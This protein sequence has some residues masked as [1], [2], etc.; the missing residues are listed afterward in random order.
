M[1]ARGVCRMWRL[2]A[3]VCLAAVFGLMLTGPALGAELRE[4]ETYVLHADEV[5][6]DDLYVAAGQVTIEGTV[7]SDVF[8]AGQ[9][10]VIEGNVH[11]DV[12]ALAQT[13]I[14]NGEVGD[15]V[16]AAGQAVQVGPDA[17]IHGDLVCGD[18]SLEIVRGAR[19]DGDLMHGGYQAVLAGD[20]GRD[21]RTAS[22]A[23]RIDGSVGRNIYAELGDTKEDE[24]PPPGAF[25]SSPGIVLPTVS[26]GL[27][28][29]EDASVGGA[30]RYTS[31][32]KAR[33]AQEANIGGPVR[34]R[35]PE[36]GVEKEEQN[37]FATW[38]L[39]QLRRLVALVLVGLLLV[40][41]FPGWLRGV[42]E[43]IEQRPLP[44]LGWGVVVL[45]AFAVVVGV[46]LF[47]T[48]MLAILFGV[49]T[50]GGVV[51][52]VLSLGAVSE[53]VLVVAFALYVA[54]GGPTV[55]SLLGGRL[56][57]QRADTGPGTAAIVQFF[58]GVLILWV[59]TAI[60]VVDIFASLAVLLFSLGG[61]W[62]WASRAIG[63]GGG[64]EPAAGV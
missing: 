31:T 10:V 42:G 43:R 36:P 29:S 24:G 62:L 61:L 52:L 63:A 48:V 22:P 56:V 60:P 26:Q 16:H 28:L 20:I 9:K 11:G 12:V 17:R 51:G 1:R 21:V 34:Q 2:A 38:A 55:I 64:Q 3:V 39:N 30:I 32:S 7:T 5:L 15:N 37:T 8:A 40:L 41:L 27:T 14:V 59:L 50:L 13:V 18:Y 33:I 6:E 46:I 25:M 4:G 47:V 53:T 44:S 54:F 49:A 23:V 57:L 35:I 45:V 58:V 19:V